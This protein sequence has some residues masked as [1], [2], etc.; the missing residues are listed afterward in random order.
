MANY[1]CIDQFC[2]MYYVEY[3]TN[4][5]YIYTYTYTYTS[6]YTNYSY[7]CQDYPRPKPVGCPED[8][9]WNVFLQ[10]GWKLKFLRDYLSPKDGGVS[11]T[12]GVPSLNN[13]NPNFHGT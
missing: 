5:L 13:L 6:T 3:K 1:V 9:S 7:S 12:G 10:R 2:C 11:K 4:V 8:T